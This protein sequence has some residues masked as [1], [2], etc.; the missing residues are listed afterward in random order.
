MTH[1]RHFSRTNS[2]GKVESPTRFLVRAHSIISQHS[3]TTR[4]RASR[5]SITRLLLCDC[6]VQNVSKRPTPAASRTV[7][8]RVA[9]V[10]FHR[11]I[12]TIFQQEANEVF[13]PL[14]AAQQER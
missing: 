5:A 12:A 6:L 13:M 4:S 9:L 2:R 3:Q 1:T 14:F 10:V 8:S 7:R 11:N